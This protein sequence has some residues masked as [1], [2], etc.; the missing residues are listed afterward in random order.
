MAGGSVSFAAP[1]PSGKWG[2][3]TALLAGVVS[4]PSPTPPPPR[5]VPG[6]LPDLS[7][8]PV[9]PGPGGVGGGRREPELSSPQRGGYVRGS[10]RGVRGCLSGPAKKRRRESSPTPLETVLQA[11]GESP[12]YAHLPVGT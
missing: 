2:L 10:L 6:S 4:L 9:F 7:C 1:V 8:G 12:H 11:R 5:P 3:A